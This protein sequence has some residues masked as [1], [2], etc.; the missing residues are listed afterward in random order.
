ML[1]MKK[2]VVILQLECRRHNCAEIDLV[3]F[4][5]V[6]IQ[7]VR[8]SRVLQIRVF[9]VLYLSDIRAG[10]NSS[11]QPNISGNQLRSLDCTL[12]HTTRLP[13]Y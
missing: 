8:H 1:S 3:C 13:R 9:P 2:C 10:S 12:S 5:F 6:S 7:K 4:A 11:N